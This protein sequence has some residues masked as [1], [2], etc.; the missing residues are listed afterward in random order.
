MDVDLS[1]AQPEGFDGFGRFGLRCCDVQLLPAPGQRGLLA[2]TGGEP[3]VAQALE[4]VGQYVLEVAAQEF[5]A[6]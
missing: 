5:G 3:V 2:A 4:S 1:N 6:G